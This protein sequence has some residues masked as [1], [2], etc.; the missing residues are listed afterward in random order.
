MRLGIE[1]NVTRMET[2]EYLK[3]LEA[4]SVPPELTT[5]RRG[6]LLTQVFGYTWK[7]QELPSSS[8]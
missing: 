7:T 1:S 8:D 5:H 4:A 6:K 3:A 2:R